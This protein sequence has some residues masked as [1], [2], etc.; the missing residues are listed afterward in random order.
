VN[1]APGPAAAALPLPDLERALEQACGVALSPGVRQTLADAFLRAA[2]EAGAPTEPFLR[3]VLA[4]EP[5]ALALLV[6]NAVVGETYFYRHPEQLAALTQGLLLPQPIGR[7]LSIWSAGCATGE[8]P[9]TLSMMLQE[10]GRAGAGDRILGTDVSA[11]ALE[12]ARTGHYGEWSLRRLEPGLRSRFFRPAGRRLSVTPPVRAPVEL[13]R[14]NL[15]ADLAPGAGFD[16]VVCRNVLIYFSAATAAAVA[17]RLV[18]ALRPGGWLVVGPVETPLLAGLPVDRHEAPGATLLRRPERRAPARPGA[19]ARRAAPAR[20]WE[21]RPAPQAARLST[22]GAA[23]PPEPEPGCAGDA[24]AECRS[25]FGEA[26]LAA[27]RGELAQAEAL[28]RR[29]AERHLCPESYLLLAMAA[30]ARGDD[31]AAADA[32]RRA[33]YLEPGLAQ[34]HAA[35]VPIYGRLG[36]PDEAARARRNALDALQ[37][38]DDETALRGVEPLTA[39]ALRL[40]LSEGATMPRRSTAPGSQ[41]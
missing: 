19:V 9:Y 39:G 35:L 27:R 15:V 2:R 16:L 7:P 24:S 30:E 3:R 18:E 4:G 23:R 31:A 38:L 10:A 26:R 11:R 32:V 22:A 1:A 37:G 13:R 36:R 33:L 12:V 28:V 5:R 29:V 14:H 20:R 25:A 34:A 21:D 8:E 6:E 41:G 17:A 40:A